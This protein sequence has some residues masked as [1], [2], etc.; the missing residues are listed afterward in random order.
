MNSRPIPAVLRW[1]I[2]E[3]SITRI[4]ETEDL[5]MQAPAML[6]DATP[7]NVLPI[8]WLQP[9]FIDERGLLK[10]AIFSLLIES[11]GRRIVVDTCLG[12]DK[13]RIVPMWNRRQGRFLE[14][15]AAAGFPR[16]QV[17][18]VVCTHLHPDHVGWNTMLVDG[19]WVPTFPNARYA[20]VAQ[21]WEYLDSRPVGPLG[22][23]AG[24]SVRPVIAAGL[25]DLVQPDHRFTDEIWLESTP[26][27]SPGHVSVRIS[28]RGEQA[29]VTGDLI[30]HPC[31][32]ARPHWCSA[33]D[34]DRHQALRTREAFIRRYGD[35]PVLIIGSHFAAPSAGRIVRD[36]EA[37]RLE[38]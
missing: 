7:E 31:Q 16:E 26:G 33:F 2:G 36:G 20:F 10:S 14:E 3:V 29:I 32:L 5:S 18:H 37:W 12:N 8:Q 13:E 22:D 34:F 9:H 1:Q 4:V 6:P 25:A 23:F 35:A 21:D 30:H 15:I 38:I 28:S 24:D 19:H 17:H 11:Q 27:H